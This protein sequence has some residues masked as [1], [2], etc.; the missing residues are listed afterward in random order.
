[1]DKKRH[2]TFIKEWY[3]QDTGF[4]NR[5]KKNEEIYCQE[6][7]ELKD[8]AKINAFPGKHFVNKKFRE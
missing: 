6:S 8:A 1:M 4:V 5:K 2:V 7:A 3:K